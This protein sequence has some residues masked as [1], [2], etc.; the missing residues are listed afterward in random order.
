MSEGQPKKAGR[1]ENLHLL[2]EVD[3]DNVL[4]EPR[5]R[6]SVQPPSPMGEGL[7][8]GS[9]SFPKPFQTPR[10]RTT[11]KKTAPIEHSDNETAQGG[12]KPSSPAAER[13]EGSTTENAEETTP[14]PSQP[15]Q[16]Q[17]LP[18]PSQQE[19]VVVSEQPPVSQEANLTPQMQEMLEKLREE[20]QRDLQKDFE[21][22]LRREREQNE[23]ILKE[24]EKQ[25]QDKLAALNAERTRIYTQLRRQEELRVEEELRRIEKS[26]EVAA[27]TAVGQ[28]TANIQQTPEKP[29]QQEE[30]ETAMPRVTRTP[31]QEESE[32]SVQMLRRPRT[33]E[34]RERP[35][36]KQR[37]EQTV[38]RR[39][40][41]PQPLVETV[42][43]Q[44]RGPGRPKKQT[45]APSGTLEEE[46]ASES[47]QS[48]V[49]PIEEEQSATD[50]GD[51]SYVDSDD[52]ETRKRQRKTTSDIIFEE[53]AD[54][55]IDEINPADRIFSRRPEKFLPSF[56]KPPMPYVEDL[57]TLQKREIVFFRR[58]LR[59]FRN[60]KNH[61]LTISLVELE[62]EAERRQWGKIPD[63]ITKGKPK[64]QHTHVEVMFHHW[65]QPFLWVEQIWVLRHCREFPMAYDTPADQVLRSKRL[66]PYMKYIR[67]YPPDLLLKSRRIEI[68]QNRPHPRKFD[69]PLTGDNLVMD[70]KTILT[71][72][73]AHGLKE[74]EP[75]ENVDFA[76][77]DFMM[78]LE[79]TQESARPLFD[80]LRR[81]RKIFFQIREKERITGETIIECPSED[82]DEEK[83]KRQG[84]RP[85][86]KRR[87]I[88]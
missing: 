36:K 78:L 83:R 71:Y 24:V 45:V 2:R 16:T 44:K 62:D 48:E 29:S 55:I 30:Q 76:M 61:I 50:D 25:N 79:E 66:T 60:L 1:G 73:G 43:Q 47:S 54:K 57:T 35:S 63:F 10:K 42:L 37:K 46:S 77:I 74:W 75:H 56:Q 31:E 32:G 15:Q 67:C 8:T 53:G 72:Y 28:T 7:Q 27:E 9:S 13:Q 23:R 59:A 3:P 34:V 64:P 40:S 20:M 4:S 82:T 88:A 22:Q 17:E 58:K 80:L 87:A 14:L 69:I 6:R 70:A 12:E 52:G 65:P 19:T 18:D 39:S 84:P 38:A 26:V 68:P 33:P 41:L 51:S 5:R 85:G 21:V 49:V 81:Y 11:S 86:G